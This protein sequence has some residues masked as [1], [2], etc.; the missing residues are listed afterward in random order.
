MKI[1]V[2][3][4]GMG[5]KSVAAAIK[6][7]MPEVQVIFKH[8]KRHLPYGSKTP[9]QLLEFV[10]PILESM[11]KQG[12]EVIVIACNSVTTTIIKDLR[13]KLTVPLIGIE[14]MIKPAAATTK[15]GTIAVCATP[16]TLASPRYKELVDQYAQNITVIE[17]DCSNWAYMIE[18]N[19][20]NVNYVS[21][22][23]KSVC[24]KGADVIVLAC[25]HYHWIREDIIAMAAEYDVQVIQPEEAI[26][27]RLKQV[28]AQLD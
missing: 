22:Q 15:T 14:P 26:I 7:A 6:H 24:K 19:A 18:E 27:R 5:G 23:I 12:C 2:F 3:D 10:V 28:I 20:V 11:Q 25:T 16:T 4:S 13:K 21:G 17:P 1:G 9:V 8:D